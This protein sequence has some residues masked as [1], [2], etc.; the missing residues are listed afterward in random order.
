MGHNRI[1]VLPKTARWREVTSLVA[2]G[3]PE[4]GGRI[5]VATL[6]AAE[7]HLQ[8]IAGDPAVIATYRLLVDVMAAARSDDFAGELGRLGLRAEGSTPAIVFVADITDHLRSSL[9]EQGLESVPGEY[10][11]L[12]L[13]SILTETVG[14]RSVSLFGATVDDLRQAFRD[15][16]SDRQFG[17][18]SQRFFGELLSRVLR[19]ALDREIPRTPMSTGAGDELLRQVDLHAHQ[20]ARIVRD[21]AADWFS[22]GRW[23]GGGRIPEDEVRRFLDVGFRKLRREVKREADR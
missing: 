7:Q 4:D 10:A 8:D 15:F 13:R 16:A 18:L 12:A 6:G 21:Y 23:E 22:K 19:S 5:A 2:G 11:S 9:N 17:N 3:T 1:G 20:S 14:T